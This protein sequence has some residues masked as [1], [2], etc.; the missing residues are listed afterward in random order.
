MRIKGWFLSQLLRFQCLTWRVHTQGH[1]R[2]A[3]LYGK[4]ERFLLCFWHGKYVPILPLFQGYN[5]CVFTSLSERGNVI[6]E[7]C[8]NFAYQCAQIPD[9]GGDESLRLMEEALAEVPAGGIAVDGPLGPYHAVKRGVIQLASTLGFLL[10]P[11]SVDA[12]RKRVFEERWDQMEIPR[13]FTKIYLVIG[14]P[15]KV[16]AI[17]SPEEAGVWVSHLAEA[18]ELLDRQASSMAQGKK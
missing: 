9:H 16:P 18:L 11:V 13:L 12:C 17:L 7:I 8:R 1:D 4:R 14:D 10:L 3:R 6:A 5:A 2:L 15:L